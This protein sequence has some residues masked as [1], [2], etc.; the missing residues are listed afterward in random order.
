MAQSGFT[1]IQLY[2]SST[3]T[4]IPSAGNLAYGELAINI[5]D[6]KLYFKNSSNVVTKIADA[7]TATGSVTGGTAGAIV[8]QSAPS[9][10]AFLNI[11]ASGYIVTS[12]GSV[13]TY[14]NPATI[15]V[16]NA[17]ASVTSTNLAGGAAYRIPYQA[18]SGIT[19]FLAAPTITG[20]VLG[21]T[22]S[23]LDWVAAPAATSSINLTGGTAGAV[24]YQSGV[25]ATSFSGVGTV[26]Q[27]L[28][29]NGTSAPTWNTLNA[30]P[31]QAG[32]AGKY[33][34]TDGS[35]ASWQ[36]TGA[37]A[38]G[39][40]WENSLVI[41]ANYTLTTGKNGMSVGPI[42]I[43]SGVVVTIPSGQRWVVL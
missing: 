8:Y 41:A 34:T 13:P 24:P 18:S 28:T 42:T 23:A 39:V 6:G 11:G 1:P 43:N 30:L 35:N 9:T 40:I 2:Y 37:S 7:A 3:S 17:T 31:S 20:Y 32:N 5:A 33:L 19:N 25:G 21:W 26:G 14:T 16:G 12:S 22:G 29:S 10:S 15:T 4:N 36:D 27:V 38:A